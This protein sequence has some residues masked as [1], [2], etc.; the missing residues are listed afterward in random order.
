MD[1]YYGTPPSP[2]IVGDN[3]ANTLNAVELVEAGVARILQ[4]DPDVST[5]KVAHGLPIVV[6]PYST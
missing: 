2:A 1:S 4:V 6:F 5:L 3:T